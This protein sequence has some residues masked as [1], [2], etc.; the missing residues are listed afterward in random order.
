L[1]SR[2]GELSVEIC[3]QTLAVKSRPL[4]SPS[5]FR[6]GESES[7]FESEFE[8]LDDFDDFDDDESL[9]ALVL[10]PP[11]HPAKSTIATSPALAHRFTDIEASVTSGRDP[12]GVE[13]ERDALRQRH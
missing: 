10:S 3:S 6:E 13:A 12:R 9:D 11:P 4:M 8:E 1:R 7:E 2:N 5:L